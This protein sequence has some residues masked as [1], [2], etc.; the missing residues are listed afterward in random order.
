MQYFLAMKG[1]LMTGAGP[2]GL[3]VKT[4]PE[5]DSPDVQYQFLA[6]SAPKVGDPMHRFPACTLVAI[7]CRPESRGWLRITAPDPTKAAGDAAEL[8]FD[9]GRQG[10]HRRRAESLAPH[11]R[12][13][14]DAAT[15]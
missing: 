5:L 7:P 6:G 13:Q 11:L 1:A 4:R 8:S 14:G 9:A 2:I 15:T 3:F 12:H 10:H